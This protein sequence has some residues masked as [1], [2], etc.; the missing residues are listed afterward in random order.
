MNFANDYKFIT[1]PK[2]CVIFLDGNGKVQTV[3]VS[4]KVADILHGDQSSESTKRRAAERH[5]VSLDAFD[6]E[7]GVFSVCDTDDGYSNAG[8]SLNEKVSYVLT[9]MD[10]KQAKLLKKIFFEKKTQKEIADVEGI[11]Q[12]AVSQRLKVAKR[13]F[14][15][16]FKKMF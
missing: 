15:K 12:A 16:I 10:P 4:Q 3:E 14:S 2:P 5:T 13:N 9:R 7:G 8:I 6:Y 1:D 11:T